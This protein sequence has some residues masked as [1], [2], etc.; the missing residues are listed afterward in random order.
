[1]FRLGANFWFKKSVDLGGVEIGPVLG[2]GQN[3]SFTVWKVGLLWGFQ[4]GP[5]I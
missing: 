3:G 2:K 5:W 1:V 4:G